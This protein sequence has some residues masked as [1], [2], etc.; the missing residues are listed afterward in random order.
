M[1][2]LAAFFVL[3]LALVVTLFVWAPWDDD[4]SSTAPGGG[5]VP[6]E[7]ADENINIEGDIDINGGDEPS[8]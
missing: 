7:G 1:V 5:D 6:A 2:A 3:A 4:N 8:Q